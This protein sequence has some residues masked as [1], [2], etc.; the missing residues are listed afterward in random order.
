[1]PIEL[2]AVEREALEAKLYSFIRRFTLKSAGDL[3]RMIHIWKSYE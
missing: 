2:V 1:M 3:R